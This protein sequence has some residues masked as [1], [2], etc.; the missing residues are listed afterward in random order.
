MIVIT[1]NKKTMNEF[2]RMQQIAGLLKESEDNSKSSSV[3]AEAE[4]QSPEDAI[5]YLEKLA[6]SGEI[7]K[8]TI[9]NIYHSLIS[10]RKKMFTAKRNPDSY[11]AAAEK[12]KATKAQ[13]AKDMAVWMK[14]A[15]ATD[16]KRQAGIAKRKQDNLLPLS[17]DNWFGTPDSKYYEFDYTDPKG[18]FDR[19]KLKD[20]W[21]ETPVSPAIA[22]KY[23]KD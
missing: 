22:A 19:Y 9:D 15:N 8:G 21:K 20:R 10:A 17:T 23:Y 1:K 6:L 3:I 7:D 13:N 11:K 5:A 2:Q 4:Y 12:A 14:K 16:A 18:G